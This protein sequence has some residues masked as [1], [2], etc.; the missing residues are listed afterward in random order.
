MVHICSHY[1]DCGLSDPQHEVPLGHI[2]QLINRY[3]KVLRR[4]LEPA[5]VSTMVATFVGSPSAAGEGSV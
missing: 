5:D 4:V 3:P 2:K 1:T